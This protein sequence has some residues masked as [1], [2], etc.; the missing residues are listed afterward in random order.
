MFQ[1][2][3]FCSQ[4]KSF[5]KIS[6]L[7]IRIYIFMYVNS[8]YFFR[9]LWVVHPCLSFANNL[10]TRVHTHVHRMYGNKHQAA[11]QTSIS[12]AFFIC[13]SFTCEDVDNSMGCTKSWLKS[14]MCSITSLETSFVSKV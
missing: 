9:N 5:K 7:N 6:K 10:S 1:T 11:L 8:C 12:I 4:N 3:R 2:I 13:D 14:F